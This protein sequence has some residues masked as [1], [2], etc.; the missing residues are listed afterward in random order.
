MNERIKELAVSTGIFDSLC[1]PF[2]EL[3]NGD[4]YS[5]VM[6]DLEKFADLIIEDAESEAISLIKFIARDYVEL[7]HDKVLWQRNDYIKRCH[8]F[9]DEYRGVEE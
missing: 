8:K 6:V 7:S 3:K 9:L 5:S 4:C 2:D 1:D